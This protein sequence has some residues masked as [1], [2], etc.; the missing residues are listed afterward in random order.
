MPAR[1]EVLMTETK[2]M[3]HLMVHGA[4]GIGVAVNRR[5]GREVDELLPALSALWGLTLSI[6]NSS[7]DYE[8]GLPGTRPPDVRTNRMVESIDAASDPR[9]THLLVACRSGNLVWHVTVPSTS[10]VD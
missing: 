7:Q 10:G 3:T 2:S 5:N 8:V 4:V 9:D 1:V 6:D